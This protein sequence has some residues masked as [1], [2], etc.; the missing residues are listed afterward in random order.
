MKRNKK[1]YRPGWAPP[2]VTAWC[3][4]HDRGCNDRY[5]RSKKCLTKQKGR[6]CRYLRVL[7][8]ASREE[9]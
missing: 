6:P 4:Y 9:G 5:M 8:P 7:V 3:D 2:N 1:T